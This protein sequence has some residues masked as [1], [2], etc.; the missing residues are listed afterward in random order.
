M[1]VLKMLVGLVLLTAAFAGG[2]FARARAVHAP[3]ATSGRQV[4][5][6]VDP[7]HP[8]YKSDKPGIAPD[9]GMKFEPVYADQ[10]APATGTA[11]PTETSTSTPSSTPT[12]T[13]TPTSTATPTETPT[14]TSAAVNTPEATATNAPMPPTN[15][16]VPIGGG[17]G[18]QGGGESN[19]AGDAG[20]GSPTA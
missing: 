3:A 5:Y 10:S 8:A 1:R 4:L 15:T 6:Y 16:S 9:C 2:Y 18:D 11:T 17:G 13:E 7:M 14:E 19:P 20:G 12:P